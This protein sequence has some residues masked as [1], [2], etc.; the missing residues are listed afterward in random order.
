MILAGLLLLYSESP[1]Q[2]VAHGRHAEADAVLLRIYRTSSAEQRTAKMKSIE[3]SI[4]EASQSMSK[5]FLWVTFKRIFTTP[6]TGRA[7]A[8]ACLVMAIS[9]LGGFNTLMY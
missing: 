8:T 6:A 1:R 9:Q 2:L 5:E 3:L 4:S 7:V